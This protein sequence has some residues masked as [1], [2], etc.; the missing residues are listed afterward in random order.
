MFFNCKTSHGLALATVNNTDVGVV[1]RIEWQ[2]Q[3]SHGAT[4]QIEYKFEP[5]LP[6]DFNSETTQERYAHAA[7]S[8]FDR[9]DALMAGEK[10]YCRVDQLEVNGALRLVGAA[11]Q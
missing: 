11:Q 9:T 7:L 6:P 4:H 2:P 1:V 5:P 3:Q 10:Q 8:H